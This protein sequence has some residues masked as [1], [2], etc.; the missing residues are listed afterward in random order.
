MIDSKNDFYLLFEQRHFKKYNKCDLEHFI[1]FFNRRNEDKCL[2]SW[3]T[4]LKKTGT[5]V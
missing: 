2:V 3:A 1:Y 4:N 5:F